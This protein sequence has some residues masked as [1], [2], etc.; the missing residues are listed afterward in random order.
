[1]TTESVKVIIRCRPLSDK[2]QK[3]KCPYIVTV[4]KGMQQVSLNDPQEDSKDML[5]AKT[6]RFDEVFDSQSTQQQVYDE[7]AF[8][9]IEAAAEGYNGKKLSL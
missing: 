9:I 3:F 2:E 1:M 5:I 8:N 4:D 7:A 6:F